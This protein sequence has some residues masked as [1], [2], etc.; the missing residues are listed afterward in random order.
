MYRL[1]EMQQTNIAEEP[2][3]IDALTTIET[4]DK[5]MREAKQGFKKKHEASRKR[6]SDSDEEPSNGHVRHVKKTKMTNKK[7]HPGSWSS[8][9]LCSLSEGRSA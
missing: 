8:S 9:L 5:K 6:A 1:V 7:Q 2:E 3:W 4:S